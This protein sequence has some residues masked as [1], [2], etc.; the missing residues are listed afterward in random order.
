MKAVVDRIEDGDLAVL[1]LGDEEI[2]LDLPRRYLPPGTAEG[3]VLH[4][5]FEKDE[6]E[7]ESRMDQMRERMAR[8]RRKSRG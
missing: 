7:T 8:L 1:L 5:T 4:L 2:Q 3:S 6:Q